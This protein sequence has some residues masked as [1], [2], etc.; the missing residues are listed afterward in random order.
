[1]HFF[2]NLSFLSFVSLSSLLNTNIHA[3]VQQS[4]SSFYVAHAAAACGVEP[5]GLT[6]IYV[7]ETVDRESQLRCFEASI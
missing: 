5:G 6:I 3:G 1:M 4:E 7:I 2:P